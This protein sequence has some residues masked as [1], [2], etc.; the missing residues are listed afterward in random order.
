[1]AHSGRFSERM[2][3]RSPGWTPR[4][5]NPS[6]SALTVKPK[7]AAGIGFHSPPTLE[8]RRLGF[9]LAAAIRKMSH[10]VRGSLAMVVPPRPIVSRPSRAVK[11]RAASR[12]PG[13]R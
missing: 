5:L 8:I 7:S 2:A 12:R 10:R 4:A 6:E 13:L 11:D 1:M 9:P 3:T